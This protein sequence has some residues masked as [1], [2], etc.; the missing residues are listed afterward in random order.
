MTGVNE[1]VKNW[2]IP[3]VDMFQIEPRASPFRSQFYQV[4]VI[5]NQQIKTGLFKK[6]SVPFEFAAPMINQTKQEA[7]GY[8][9]YYIHELI[10]DGS[11]PDEV[12]K[13]NQIDE[14]LIRIR[15][16][17]LNVAMM[18]KDVSDK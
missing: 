12:I 10:K 11:L 2:R 14:N 3:G 16:D 18:E 6:T 17:T 7:I 8:A 15:I 13:F 1:L 5:Y 4:R 9:S